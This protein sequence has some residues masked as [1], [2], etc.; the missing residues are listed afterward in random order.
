MKQRVSYMID[1]SQVGAEG[2]SGGTFFGH[3][4]IL[5]PARFRAGLNPTY[6]REDVRAG[7]KS[8]LRLDNRSRTVAAQNQRLGAARV[9]KRY[10]GNHTAAL[11]T[12]FTAFFAPA[13]V[14][15]TNPSL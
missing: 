12:L 1:I 13:A 4:L 3:R 2:R 9:N 6:S 10:A 11:F 5:W 14:A 7:V 15:Q 8:R